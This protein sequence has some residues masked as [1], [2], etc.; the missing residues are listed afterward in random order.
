MDD[1]GGAR[2]DAGAGPRPR[3][4]HEHLPLFLPLLLSSFC[5]GSFA[6]FEPQAQ[7]AGDGETHG[8][9]AGD[10]D[11]SVDRL[12]LIGESEV[13]FRRGGPRSREVREQ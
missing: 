3:L 13:L 4:E 11:V 12:E 9:G 1:L 2:R 7:G 5:S 10:H 8:A 6:S